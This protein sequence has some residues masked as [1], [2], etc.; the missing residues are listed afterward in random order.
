[1]HPFLRISIVLWA[2][3]LLWACLPVAS[4]GVPGQLAGYD[5][6]E[7][8][9]LTSQV[10]PEFAT[11][12]TDHFV[13]VY[14]GPSFLVVHSARLTESAHDDFYGA[15]NNFDVRPLGSRLFW[16]CFNKHES[17]QKYAQQADQGDMSLLDGYYSAKTNRVA[18]VWPSQAS[19]VSDKEIIPASATQPP[20]GIMYASPTETSTTGLYPDVDAPR[21]RHEAAHQLAF[22]S[23]LFKRGVMYP[24]WASEGLAVNFEYGSIEQSDIAENNAE[25]CQYLIEGFQSG[26]LVP[27]D[28]FVTMTNVEFGRESTSMVYAQAWGFFNF[29]YKEYRPQLKK[30]LSRLADVSVG[31]RT[32]EKIRHEFEAAFGSMHDVARRWDQYLV[33]LNAR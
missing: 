29:L 5:L 15:F 2:V 10:C 1:M 9:R 3:A 27:F 20:P 26:K 33:C 13:M 24:I 14:E 16:A 30:Y 28:D 18:L 31:R 12:V 32:P 22:N 21:I 23:G 25:R 17:Y 19:S 8:S 4:A 7:Y 11:Y 6:S